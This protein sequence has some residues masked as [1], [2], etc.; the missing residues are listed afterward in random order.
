MKLKSFQ[1]IP[2]YTNTIQ[3]GS[4]YEAG[5]AKY[6]ALGPVAQEQIGTGP[7]IPFVFIFD[8]KDMKTLYNIKD[9]YPA[10]ISH[11]ALEK[12]RKDRPNLYSNGGLLPT[13]DEEWRRLRMPAQKP[14]LDDKFP[15]Q[16]VDVIDRASL[17][18]VAHLKSR[19]VWDDILEELKKHFLEITTQVVLG[20]SL[21]SL[22]NEPDALQL[23][24]SAADTN[25]CILKTDQCESWKTKETE[26]YAIIRKS[27]EFI[28]Y[29]AT[30]CIAERNHLKNNPNIFNAYIQ[31]ARL[32]YQ[33]RFTLINDFLLA[34]I[35]TSAN[36]MAFML[37]ELSK[38]AELQNEL[39]D[40][41]DKMNLDINTLKNFR[42]NF[43]LAEGII[44]EN[45]RF[46]PISVGVGRSARQKCQFSG[47]EIPK[48]T[49]VVTQNQV[50]SRL[51]SYCP[52]KPNEF[53]PY[54]FTQPGYEALH[55][56]L[57]LPFGFGARR[58]IGKK[59][60]ATSLRLLLIRL[61]QAFHL[62]YV[63]KYP[64][65]IKCVTKLI[66]EPEYPISLKFCA[67]K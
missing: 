50:S 14:M 51:E 9:E 61:S 45:F 47:Y 1:D 38:N 31:D 13:N 62:K 48:E 65:E 43:P 10:R 7:P 44:Q 35:E 55:P 41:S 18:F 37:Y 11:K 42:R 20:T 36:T 4:L 15:K 34:G 23:I 33:D 67:R 16:F 6:K 57:I 52:Y 60:A 17:D 5:L 27:Q 25:S 32:S 30:K 2:K 3:I 29:M 26:D 64:E 28:E 56:G 63:G 66:N 58:C 39:F 12:Y 59:L 40:E 46:H 8:P 54:R 21:K 53:C 19:P 22:E 49:Y 24:K